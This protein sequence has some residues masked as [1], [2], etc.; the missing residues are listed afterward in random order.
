MGWGQGN[1]LIVPITGLLP[2]P[3][4][5]V[6]VSNP[7]NRAGLFFSLTSLSSLVYGTMSVEGLN[8]IIYY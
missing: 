8:D 3:V 1:C 6:F 2:P 4:P 7:P 5:G